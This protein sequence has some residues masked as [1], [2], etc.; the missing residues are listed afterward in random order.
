[1]K[2]NRSRIIRKSTN[3][4]FVLTA[5]VTL[6]L[7]NINFGVSEL[8]DVIKNYYSNKD[9]DL[10]SMR[11]TRK[12][13]RISS[14]TTGRVVSNKTNLRITDR[15]LMGIA[16]KIY[17]NETGGKRDDLVKWNSGENFPSLGIGHFIWAKSLGSNGIFGESLPELVN[18][19]RAKGVKVPR[20]LEQNR[21]S[22]WRSRSELIRKKNNR[23]PEITE[24]IDF[25]DKT[26]DTQILYIF[27]RLQN[28]LEKMISASYDKENLRYQF[29]RVAN[30]PNGLYALIDYVNFKGEGIATS[31]SYNHQG[32]GLRQ[33]LENMKGRGEGPNALVEFSESA[34][35]ILTKR[36]KNAPR[37]E[38]RWI[39]GW[40]KR[41]DTY[42][43]FEIN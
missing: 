12:D 11:D 7:S 42:K 40:T 32:W 6:L 8:D 31:G 3:K 5:T 17:Q 41:A 2:T 36:A 9:Y 13:K 26:R 37:N 34:K 1:M 4:V 14:P 10:I 21:F 22:P 23:D 25:F 27:E 24:L 20:V 38:W 30:S 18:F 39:A 35:Y 15:E 28:S 16:D 19:Y 33:V 43:N 29:Y